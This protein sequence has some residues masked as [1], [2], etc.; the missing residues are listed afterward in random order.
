MIVQFDVVEVDECPIHLPLQSL[1]LVVSLPQYAL[2]LQ[3]G[4]STRGEQLDHRYT[5]LWEQER[6]LVKELN[7]VMDDSHH[8]EIEANL[9]LIRY[10]VTRILDEFNQDSD[11][12]SDDDIFE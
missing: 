2:D 8:A 10:E 5:T 11:L 1:Q 6:C 7:Y 12:E 3:V 9:D 4:L